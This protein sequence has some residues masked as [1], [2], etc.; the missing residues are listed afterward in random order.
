MS[1]EITKEE[2]DILVRAEQIRKRTK[3]RT[4]LAEI[5]KANG[6]TIQV[7]W[8]YTANSLPRSG[9]YFVDRAEVEKILAI[10]KEAAK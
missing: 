4:A 9:E 3:L 10:L 5:R 1:D 7:S 2:Q 6:V 8:Q